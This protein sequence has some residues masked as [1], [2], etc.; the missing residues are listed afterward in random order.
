MYDL[1][2]KCARYDRPPRRGRQRRPRPRHNPR[3]PL[4]RTR[5]D[6]AR[7]ARRPPECAWVLWDQVLMRRRINTIP[8]SWGR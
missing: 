2:T 4:R 1:A 8:T 7:S 5:V 6:A 3:G